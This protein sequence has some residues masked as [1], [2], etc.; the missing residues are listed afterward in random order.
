MNLFKNEAALFKNEPYFGHLSFRRCVESIACVF[1]RHPGLKCLLNNP[2]HATASTDPYIME[3]RDP[4]KSNAINSSLWEIQSLQQHALPG[5]ATAARFIDSPLPSVE[6]DISKILDNTGDDIFDK[7]VKKFSK[8]IVLQFEKPNGAC[9]G[10]NEHVM[11]YWDLR[12]ESQS[13]LEQIPSLSDLVFGIFR[14]PQWTEHNVSVL[15]VERVRLLGVNP[16]KSL[17]FGQTVPC[18]QALYGFLSRH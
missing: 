8:L 17:L 15:Y 13:L 3:E 10:K 2:D 7:E 12:T 5:V 16:F 11:Q 4:V 9:L 14:L 18:K 6:W 1:V